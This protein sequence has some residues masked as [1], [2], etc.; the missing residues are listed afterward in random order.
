MQFFLLELRL[1]FFLTIVSALVSR[2]LRNSLIRAIYDP[3]RAMVV[4][5]VAKSL[6][7][8]MP[9]LDEAVDRI[10]VKLTPRFAVANELGHPR[11]IGA[12]RSEKLFHQR[13]HF[14]W[15]LRIF[16]VAPDRADRSD[17]PL[18]R[19]VCRLF[20]YNHRLRPFRWFSL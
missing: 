6:F 14:E 9:H 7:M 15:Q 18:Q 2:N 11:L 17:I 4:W 13:L 3:A 8:D 16:A 10:A 20:F 12:S 1:A 19:T 5:R